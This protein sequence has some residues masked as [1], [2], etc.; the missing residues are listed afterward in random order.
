[1][2]PARIILSLFS[3]KNFN[4][5]IGGCQPFQGIVSWEKPTHPFQRICKLTQ[6]DENPKKN[7]KNPTRKT[8]YMS[9]KLSV[10]CH[11]ECCNFYNK[12]NQWRFNPRKLIKQQENSSWNA[13]NQENNQQGAVKRNSCIESLVL[14]EEGECWG[15]EDGEEHKWLNPETCECPKGEI[16]CHGKEEIPECQKLKWFPLKSNKSMKNEKL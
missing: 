9:I 4:C 14:E 13:A 8:K 16:H 11:Y 12:N 7:L 2:L 3:F 5:Y 1:M 15:H 6:T 10:C